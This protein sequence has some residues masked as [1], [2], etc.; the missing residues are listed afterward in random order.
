MRALAPL[1]LLA[2]GCRSG[3]P[4]QGEPVPA[5]QATMTTEPKPPVPLPISLAKTFLDAPFAGLSVHERG[6][7]LSDAT[8]VVVLFHGYGAEGDDLVSLAAPL[9]EPGTAF[10]FPEAPISLPAGGR[11]W[12]TRDRS[13]FE[14]GYQRALAFIQVIVRDYP[15]AKLV[16]G[17]FSQGA[18]LT[19]N[20]LADAPPQ[21][22]GA[23][24]FSPADLL[25]HAPSESSPRVPLLISHGSRD[26]VLP[27]AGGEAMRDRFLAL[28]YPVT[29]AP[30]VGPHTISREALSGA[31][32][33]LSPPAGT[34]S[35]GGRTR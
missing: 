19:S 10:V 5:A 25:S 7:P 16:I 6:V 13:D 30:F 35:E 26:Q 18:M 23:L 20:L 17:G 12:F 2:L 21:L 9:A 1:I 11:A 27:F 14:Q 8:Q 4:P 24:I 28:G 34:P 32:Q 31:R 3:S 29:W 15:E 33:I 22:A